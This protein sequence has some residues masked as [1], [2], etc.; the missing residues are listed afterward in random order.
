MSE[1]GRQPWDSAALG[2]DHPEEAAGQ[3]LCEW[4]C[5]TRLRSFPLHMTMPFLIDYNLLIYNFL[6]II[7]YPTPPYPHSHTQVGREPL[8]FRDHVLVIH[9]FDMTNQMGE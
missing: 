6:L 2:H 7:I 1:P 9:Q 4:R 3:A 5:A 8:E